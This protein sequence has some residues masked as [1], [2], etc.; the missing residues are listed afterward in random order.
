VRIEPGVVALWNDLFGSGPKYVF[1]LGTF[2]CQRDSLEKVAF[3]TISSQSKW[4]G[5]QS[6]AQEMVMV[7]RGITEY[8][9][10]VS[11]IQCFHEVLTISVE[12]FQEQDLQGFVNFRGHL[13]QYIP[14]IR[15]I[16]G[17]SALLS[18]YDIEIALSALD[19]SYEKP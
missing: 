3:F 7:P 8:L 16:L 2:V 17:R 4:A 9:Y 5:I 6:H 14:E 1:L 15:N 13:R 10:K 18:D 19:G 11:Y 12:S